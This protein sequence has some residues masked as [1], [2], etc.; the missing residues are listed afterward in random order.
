MKKALL[1]NATFLSIASWAENEPKLPRLDIVYLKSAEYLP[2][3]F[4]HR[5]KE[6]F[7]LF[8]LRNISLENMF[9]SADLVITTQ[10]N[11][12]C[13]RHRNHIIYFQ[14]HLKQYYDLFW[15]SFNHQNR[16]KKK[17][18]FLLLCAISRIADHIYL[19]P[20]LQ[21]S[22]VLVN[23]ATVGERVK[24]YNR[25]HDF[26]IVHPGCNP[27]KYSSNV[28]QGVDDEGTDIE[29]YK[30]SYESG[31]QDGSSAL[32]LAFS[33]LNVLQKGIDII[34]ETASI[35][36]QYKFVIAGPNDSS[37]DSVCTSTLPDNLVII[38]REFS[39]QE[40]DALF[41]ACDVFLA[42][43]V[44]EDFGIAPLEANSYG[45][46]VIYC[47]DSG[48]IV[49]TQID[50]ITGYCCKRDAAS[51]AQGIKYCLENKEKMASRCVENVRRYSWGN[52]E[53]AFAEH[54]TR[55][56]AKQTRTKESTFLVGEECRLELEKQ[57]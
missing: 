38:C 16:L 27:P 24:K 14:H 19:T 5:L 22:N 36:S 20:N 10:P 44:E 35:M 40:K 21:R 34:I 52:F 4:P 47:K 46:P 7:R 15:Y 3:H 23:S 11:S 9:D 6:L 12:H 41:K 30:K 51:L 39:D 42:P 45:K 53:K 56:F 2:N 25:F 13:I 57:A 33:R 49:R 1:D 32:I 55:Y 31:H 18:I 17:A 50:R 28:I 8:Y 37:I 26:S 48:E 43:Y 54:V 29:I